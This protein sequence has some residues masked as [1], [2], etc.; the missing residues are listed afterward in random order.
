MKINETEHFNNITIDWLTAPDKHD[1]E[2][3]GH[4]EYIEYPLSKNAGTASGNILKTS[5]QIS[6]YHA[7]HDY[8]TEVL[9]E[10][11]K[12]GRFNGEFDKAIFSAG[13]AFGSRVEHNEFI[14][15]C[16]IPYGEG[17]TLFRHASKFEFDLFHPTTKSFESLFFSLPIYSLNLLIGEGNTK[18]LLSS[19]CISDSPSVVS[20]HIPYR[21][22]NILKSA[23]S[24]H[25]QGRM[26]QLY[27]QAKVL[28]YLCELVKYVDEKQALLPYKKTLNNTAHQ[29]YKLLSTMDGKLPSVIKLAEETGISAQKLSEDFRKEFGVTI[30]KFMSKKRL[31][32]AHVA[33]EETKIPL[34]LLSANLGYSHVN[35]FNAAFKREFG[36]SPGSL[37]RK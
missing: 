12:L 19:L 29:V 37:R 32:E 17:L 28:E 21:I 11:F 24:P 36:Y 16:H 10:T 18:K 5:H 30:Y 8:N 27:S 14:P 20:I 7:K 31:E 25:L 9:G 26:K 35:H 3:E 1:C 33:I 23:I 22:N 6:V 13:V 34:K 4:D 15:E 2:I